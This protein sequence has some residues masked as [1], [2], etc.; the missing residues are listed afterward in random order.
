[1]TP[2]EVKELKVQFNDLLDKGFIKLSIY[3]WCTLV[4]FVIKKD[5]SLR[6]CIDY[7]Q[8]NKFTINNKYPLPRTD[9]LGLM[10]WFIK[11]KE[12]ATFKR[13]TYEGYHKLRVREV[14]N[15]KMIFRKRYSHFELLVM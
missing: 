11:S 3:P 8:L 2:A 7:L 12:C 14:D 9:Y 10:T 15:Q 6:M 4:L 1:M 5:R 13:F